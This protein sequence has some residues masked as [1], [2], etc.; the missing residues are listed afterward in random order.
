MRMELS[1]RVLYRF[2]LHVRHEFVSTI[3]ITGLDRA[4]DDMKVLLNG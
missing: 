3:G 2:R 1:S 4:G